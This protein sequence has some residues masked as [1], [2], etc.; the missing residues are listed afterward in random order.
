MTHKSKAT[1]D[2]IAD[3]CQAEHD[4][5]EAKLRYRNAK[6]DLFLRLMDDG[7]YDLFTMKVAQIKR[8]G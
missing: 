8:L 1:Q 5:K 4:L 2:L 7:R 3:F 6:E